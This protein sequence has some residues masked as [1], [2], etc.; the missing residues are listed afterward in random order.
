[1]KPP[2]EVFPARKKPQ[3]DRTGR[4]FHYLFFTVFPNYY[5]TCNV[6]KQNAN[7]NS[8]PVLYFVEF[9][10]KTTAIY[11]FTESYG[12]NERIGCC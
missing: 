10:M 4:P 6:S 11:E 5:D 1:M 2:E 9:L 3:F 12:E 7:Q 8:F